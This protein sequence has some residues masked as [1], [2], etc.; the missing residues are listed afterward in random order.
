[1]LEEPKLSMSELKSRRP[2]SLEI[3]ATPSTSN[4]VSPDMQRFGSPQTPRLGSPE[5]VPTSPASSPESSPSGTRPGQ[6]LQMRR[7]LLRVGGAFHHY[8][9]VMQS[10][11]YG[12]SAMAGR[13]GATL[14]LLPRLDYVS[15]GLRSS[16]ESE[17][18]STADFLSRTAFFNNWS[19]AS[20]SRLYFW[21]GRK[22]L[23]PQ[24]DIVT[25]GD[26]AQFCFFIRRGSCDVLV[27]PS[28]EELE[29]ER[30]EAEAAERSERERLEIAELRK[31]LSE[32]GRAPEE[33]TQFVQARQAAYERESAKARRINSAGGSPGGM[34]A[35]G[36]S[37]EYL[38]R[39]S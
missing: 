34:R 21:F 37:A 3:A 33:V 2:G 27:R 31:Q 12:Y 39:Y 20:L 26:D 4:A 7:T 1:M 38:L 30:D 10:K 18:R 6:L 16:V 28:M 9:M 29:R 19:Q 5:Q 36:A 24:Q 22:V 35:G 15:S 14:L 23:P 17:M 32:Q 13:H 25:Q 8:P 11:H